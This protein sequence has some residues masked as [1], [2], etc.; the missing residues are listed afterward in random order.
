RGG[1]DAARG[2]PRTG[3]R[4]RRDVSAARSASCD[5]LIEEPRALPSALVVRRKTAAEIPQVLA[6]IMRV[7]PAVN[8]PARRCWWWE[9]D[10]NAG[11]RWRRHP[12]IA[13]MAEIT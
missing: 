7:M 6:R 12:N 1:G 3:D 4:R 5:H 9:D 8:A 10:P 11:T 13:R 2:P